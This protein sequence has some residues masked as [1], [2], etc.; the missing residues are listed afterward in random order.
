MKHSLRN[1]AFLCHL[2]SE[3]S[4]RNIYRDMAHLW[5]VFDVQS[6]GKKTWSFIILVVSKILVHFSCFSSDLLE[7]GQGQGIICFYGTWAEL[8]NHLGVISIYLGELSN[9]RQVPWHYEKR[10]QTP[11]KDIMAVYPW[12][13]ERIV[14][15]FQMNRICISITLFPIVF[16]F[17]C[18]AHCN[19]ERKIE[20]REY[21]TVYIESRLFSL[22]CKRRSSFT[23]RSLPTI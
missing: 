4:C 5:I 2:L 12:E 3:Y 21:F 11:L 10:S 17:Y 15:E 23:H 18:H 1:L 16:L 7:T 9:Y 6:L 14:C 22:L 20:R 13:R 19:V 8:N